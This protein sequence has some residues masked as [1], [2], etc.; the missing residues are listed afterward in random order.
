MQVLKLILLIASRE[1]GNVECF[2]D[3]SSDMDTQYSCLRQAGNKTT[4]KNVF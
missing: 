1:S 3:L 4:L 2:F